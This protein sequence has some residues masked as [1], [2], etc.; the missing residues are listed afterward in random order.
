[1]IAAAASLKARK[2]QVTEWIWD[3]GAAVDTVPKAALV[4]LGKYC[5]KPEVPNIISTANGNRAVE[6]EILLRL[7]GLGGEVCRPLV[8]EGPLS[9][10]P[11][12]LCVWDGGAWG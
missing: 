4:G 6:E 5:T 1:L 8:L 7:P 12:I 9:S 10:T 2:A 3:T 11:A